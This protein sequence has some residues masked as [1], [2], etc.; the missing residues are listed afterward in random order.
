MRSACRLMQSQCVAHTACGRRYL[1]PLDGFENFPPLPLGA[2]V[3]IGLW[4]LWWSDQSMQCALSPIRQFS[5]P[6]PPSMITE[7][8][9]FWLSHRDVAGEQGV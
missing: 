5:L 3:E 7:E 9:L 4:C 6:L 1:P 8:V 2:M